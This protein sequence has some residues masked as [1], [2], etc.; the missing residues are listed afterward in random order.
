MAPGFQPAYDGFAYR[1]ERDR[2]RDLKQWESQFRACG[3]QSRGTVWWM[4]EI[5]MPR[6]A[7]PNAAS[8]RAYS[9]NLN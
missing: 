7:T 3:Y 5:P 8:R 2:W 4:G 6:P 1:D 9:R